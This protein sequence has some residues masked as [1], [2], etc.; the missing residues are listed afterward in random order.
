[1]V[2]NTCNGSCGFTYLS[3]SSSPSLQTISPTVASSGSISLTGLNLNLGTASPVVVL[4]NY[5]TGEVT[6]V[7]TTITSSATSLNFTLPQVESGSYAVRVR[8]DPI[9]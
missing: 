4:E 2:D 6:L 9:G 8:L 1:M 7:N 3:S 5:E